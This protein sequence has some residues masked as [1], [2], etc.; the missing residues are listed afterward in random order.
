[1]AIIGNINL[2]GICY[3]GGK[4]VGV[5]NNG[6]VTYS[7]DGVNWTTTTITGNSLNRIY[8]SD[9]KFVAAGNRGT[10]VTSTNGVD[11]TVTQLTSSYNLYGI[12]P[13]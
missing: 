5:G 10:V 1:M 7:T 12:C 11:W 6:I 4:Y 9:G 13:A 8:Y 2:Y 3:G